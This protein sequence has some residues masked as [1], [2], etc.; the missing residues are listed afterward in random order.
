M[1]R[2]YCRAWNAFEETGSIG[3]VVFRNEYSSAP[4]TIE[5][6]SQDG[7]VIRR[8]NFDK[9]D[10]HE[11]LHI[12]DG[13]EQTYGVEKVAQDIAYTNAKPVRIEFTDPITGNTK[14]FKHI[15]NNWPE[16]TQ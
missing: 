6:H 1:L 11:F 13:I 14:H 10:G 5:E 2:L 8:Y 7:K 3:T 4:Q 16:I 15:E 12:E 9:Q